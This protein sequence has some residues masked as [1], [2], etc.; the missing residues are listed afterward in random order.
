VSQNEKERRVTTMNSD[1]FFKKHFEDAKRIR[2]ICDDLRFPVEYSPVF[3]NIHIRGIDH[4]KSPPLPIEYYRKIFSFL[5]PE[6]DMEIPDVQPEN[7]DNPFVERILDLNIRE[8]VKE[9]DK[10]MEN[11]NIRSKFFTNQLKMM[12]RMYTDVDFRTHMIALYRFF[13]QPIIHEYDDEKIRKAFYRGI[14]N[15]INE[16]INDYYEKNNPEA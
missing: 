11:N 10:I 4:F 6:S 12:E 1:D 16:Q 15:D 13:V 3:V 7:Q 5:N 14:I 2:A 8:N 9:W